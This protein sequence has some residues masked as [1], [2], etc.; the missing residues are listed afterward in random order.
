MGQL[1]HEGFVLW[2]VVLA[3][4]CTC[5]ALGAL[6]AAFFLFGGEKMNPKMKL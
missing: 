6:E 4:P 1:E 3:P 2:V 5:T